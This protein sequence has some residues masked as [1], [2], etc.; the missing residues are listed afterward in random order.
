MASRLVLR[1]PHLK[2]IADYRDDWSTKQLNRQNSLFYRLVYALDRR[3]EQRW[4]ASC[5]CFVSVSKTLIDRIAAFVHKPGYLVTNGYFP[6]DYNTGTPPENR[7]SFVVAYSGM[8]YPEQNFE[9]FLEVFNNVRLLYAGKIKLYLRFIGLEAFPP[10]KD[11]VLR[12]TANIS[13]NI[14]IIPLVPRHTCID[15]E[16]ASDV[17]LMMAYGDEKGIP[18]SKLFQYLGHQKPIVVFPGDGDIID[19]IVA[20]E[21]RLGERLPSAAHAIEFLKKLIEY[22]LN[23]NMNPVPVSGNAAAIYSRQVQTERLSEIFT[24]VLRED[25]SE[26][27]SRQS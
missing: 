14:E 16:A 18:S 9:A 25:L 12:L 7:D 2:W 13:D 19:R 4:L 5:H 11:R 6:E 8:L 20:D 17:L 24:M 23:Y 15:L 26:R 1:H 22:K 27:G 10:G 3:S 21:S